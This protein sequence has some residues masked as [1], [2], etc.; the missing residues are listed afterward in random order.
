MSGV[1]MKGPPG[2][3]R[4]PF[5]LPG[6]MV[7][8]KAPIKICFQE[9]PIQNIYEG[10]K[11]VPSFLM[12]VDEFLKW[13]RHFPYGAAIRKTKGVQLCSDLLGVTRDSVFKWLT[14]KSIPNSVSQNLMLVLV[15]ENLVRL[16]ERAEDFAR[17]RHEGQTRKF[18]NVPY[19][20]HPEAVAGLAAEYTRDERVLAAAWLHDTMED[21]G[22]T[23]EELAAEFGPYVATLVFLLTNDEE[24]KKRVRKVRYMTRKLCALPPDALLIK[25]CDM[26]HNMT[27]TRSRRQAETYREILDRVRER[28]A[29]AW[30]GTH[31]ALGGRI[32]EAYRGK[33]F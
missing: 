9:V 25:L 11:C 28:G 15:R 6:V 19:I 29:A 4:R 1:G 21:C 23:Y 24:E 17:H 31:E 22:A 16:V 7:S 10:N 12:C 27:E 32:M 26:L 13:L 33:G 5:F 2:R 30:N 18:T 8:F 14:R 20:S 3:F